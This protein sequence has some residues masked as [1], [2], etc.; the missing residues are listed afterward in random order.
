MK[1][2]M[3]GLCCIKS[4]VQEILLSIFKIDGDKLYIFSL[5]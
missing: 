4:K 2:L 5:N 3:E 1:K